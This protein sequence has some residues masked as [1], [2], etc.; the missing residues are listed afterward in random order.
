MHN[1]ACKSKKKLKNKISETNIIVPGKPKNINKLISPK[2]NNLGH[3]KLT[4]PISVTNL[5]LKR[6]PI[7]STIKKEFVD[8]KAWLISIENEASIKDDCPL[9]TQIVS[10]C[11]STT[12]E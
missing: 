5:V 10:Q 1:E 9:K 12:V 8:N 11:I 4:P 3:R 2:E 6:R 7:A